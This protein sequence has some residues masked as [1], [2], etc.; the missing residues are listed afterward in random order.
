MEQRVRRLLFITAWFATEWQLAYSAVLALLYSKDHPVSLC[1]GTGFAFVTII[2]IG[3]GIAR[4]RGSLGRYIQMSW[5][6]GFWTVNLLRI[7]LT[8]WLALEVCLLA[9]LLGGAVHLSRIPGRPFWAFEIFMI[10][11]PIGSIFALL[12][13]LMSSFR[14]WRPVR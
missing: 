5:R 7:F 13:G 3:I 12:G 2:G 1:Y 6:P 10:G 14:S 8:G 11:I 4:W 9:V